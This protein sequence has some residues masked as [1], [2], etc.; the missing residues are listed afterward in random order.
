M[1]FRLKVRFARD[2]EPDLLSW[3]YPSGNRFARAFHVED[4]GT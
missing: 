3:R 4:G 1:F 2:M